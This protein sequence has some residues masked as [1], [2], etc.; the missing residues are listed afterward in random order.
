MLLNRFILC[1]LWI[2]PTLG[3]ATST[4]NIEHWKTTNGAQVYFIQANELPMVDI[5]IIFDAG[6]ARDGGKFGLAQLSN[7][8]LDEGAGNLDADAIAERF[9]NLGA[10]FSTDSARDMA[11]INLRSLTKEDV[12]T[13]ALETTALILAK[14]SV[15]DKSFI[16]IRSQMEQALQ[17]QEQSPSSL[18]SRSF[19]EFLYGD[20]PYG[21][22]SLGTAKTLATLTRNDVL[23]FYRKYYVEKNATISMVGALT[24]SQAEKLTK[25]LMQGIPTGDLASSL[26]QVTVINASKE[27][28]IAYPSTQTTIILGTLGITR[29]DPDYFPLYVGNHILGGSGLVS[30]LSIELRE[31]RGLTYGVSSYFVPMHSKG[32]YILSLQTRNEQ[33]AEALKVL[34]QTLKDFIE[35]GPTEEELTLAKQNIVGSF[36]LNLNSN[37]KKVQQ[38]AAIGFYHLPLDYL[39]QFVSKIESITADQIRIAFKN[40]INLNQIVTVMAGENR[41]K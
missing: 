11:I 37:G 18:A 40:R 9:D 41:E 4:N 33:A 26:P 27:N 35:N 2:I 29:D 20:H 21:H 14:P 24:H 34:N 16:R 3:H 36:P 15:P 38:L 28:T 7:A 19:Y 39:D 25:T 17:R 6:S 5:R 31:K 12:L 13:S 23:D 10:Q 30:R 1:L 22:Q 32:P 8:L